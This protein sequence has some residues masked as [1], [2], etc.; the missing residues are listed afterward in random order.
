MAQ[1][2]RPPKA[3]KRYQYQSVWATTLNQFDRSIQAMGD[4]GF[5]LAPGGLCVQPTYFYCLMRREYAA[6]APADRS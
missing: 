2:G 3:P 4:S 6:Q 5:E 1:R